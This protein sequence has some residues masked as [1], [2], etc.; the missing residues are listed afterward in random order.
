MTTTGEKAIQDINKDDWIEGKD[1]KTGETKIVR[2][3]TVSSQPIATSKADLWLI[4]KDLFG[5]NL[6]SKDIICTAGLIPTNA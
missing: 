3:H 6:P 1:I 4:E 5:E 2:V